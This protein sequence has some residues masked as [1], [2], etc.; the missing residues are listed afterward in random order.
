MNRIRQILAILIS[1][2]FSL[3]AAAQEYKYEVTEKKISKEEFVEAYKHFEEYNLIRD[4]VIL[5]TGRYPTGE[6][7]AD[8]WA[9]NWCG[10]L[11]RW[12][13]CRI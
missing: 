13:I 10:L 9:A 5:N 7:I 3:A 8:L 1:V 11:Q 6:Y 12:N 4:F 2:Q